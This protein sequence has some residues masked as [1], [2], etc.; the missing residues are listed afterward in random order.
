MATEKCPYTGN[1]SIL[2]LSSSC[3]S[4]SLAIQSQTNTAL[5]LRTFIHLLSF[6]TFRS[7]YSDDGR[8]EQPKHAAG[9]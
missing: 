9:K 2:A 1:T 5:E 7:L 8:M 3:A 6:N 4:K